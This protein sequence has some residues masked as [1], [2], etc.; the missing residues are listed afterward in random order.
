[1]KGMKFHSFIQLMWVIIDVAWIEVLKLIGTVLICLF[2]KANTETRNLK[3]IL[4]KHCIIEK[5]VC[6]GILLVN[7]HFFMF[8]TYS[9]LSSMLYTL[10]TSCPFVEA[11]F[12]SYI[13]VLQCYCKCSAP[14]QC[15]CQ[16]SIVWSGAHTYQMMQTTVVPPTLVHRI[17]PVEF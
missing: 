9:V 3:N 11:F 7:L 13:T 16:S 10:K 2:E 17:V 5:T 14:S 1:M 4:G 15:W 8:F 6:L 12:N